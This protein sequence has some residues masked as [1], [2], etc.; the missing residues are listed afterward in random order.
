MFFSAGCLRP[1]E[2]LYFR[3]T[4]RIY[5]AFFIATLET[6]LQRWA[7]ASLSPSKGWGG[8]DEGYL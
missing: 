7:E 2:I 6:S 5:K 1:V 3:L 4:L 8:V